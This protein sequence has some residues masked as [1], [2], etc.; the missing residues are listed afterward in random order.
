MVISLRFIK[1]QGFQTT[2]LRRFDINYL[3]I[4]FEKENNTIN[5]YI[6]QWFLLRKLR[7]I[8]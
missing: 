6:I 7:F 1:K 3:Q 2:L 8:N 4:G 5:Y